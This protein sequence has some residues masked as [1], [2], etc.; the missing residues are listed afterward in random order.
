M[1]GE[2]DGVMRKLL[3]IA[4]A[5]GLTVGVFST[6][7]IAT[8]NYSGGAAVQVV[9][10]AGPGGNASCPATTIAGPKLDPPANFSNAYLIVTINGKTLDWE[11][12]DLGNETYDMAVVIVKGGPNSAIYTY[13]Y[14]ANPAFDDSD[15]GLAA[16]NNPNGGGQPKDYGLSN[17]KFCFDPKGFGDN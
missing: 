15:E 17:I 10:D 6:V 7:A 4:G 8:H 13:D 14:T 9:S 2:E 5:L 12:T 3:A 16:P 1:R 11:F